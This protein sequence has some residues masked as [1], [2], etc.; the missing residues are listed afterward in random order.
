M[1]WMGALRQ[2]QQLRVTSRET[3]RG[4]VGQWGMLAEMKSSKPWAWLRSLRSS[5]DLGR[6]C[7]G[8]ESKARDFPG[9]PGVRTPRFHCRGLGFDRWS[10]N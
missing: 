2:R 7:R 10:G 9:G 8:V 4:I 3:G 6:S 1:G 5:R